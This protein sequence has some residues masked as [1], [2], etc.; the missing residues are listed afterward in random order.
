MYTPGMGRADRRGRER[1]RDEDQSRPAGTTLADFMITGKQSQKQ[2]KKLASATSATAVSG[3]TSGSKSNAAAAGGASSRQTTSASA[4]AGVVGDAECASAVAADDNAFLPDTN[5]V[6][7]LYSTVLNIL[8][9]TYS[10]NAK[11][12]SRT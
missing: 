8:Q 12:N 6:R 3:S 4:G 1:D 9:Y 10:S 5:G 11:F 2:K 7:F